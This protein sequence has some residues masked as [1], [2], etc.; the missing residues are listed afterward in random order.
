M[1][2][3]ISRIVIK[4]SQ[5]PYNW[6]IL[7]LPSQDMLSFSVL[8]VYIIGRKLLHSTKF[9]HREVFNLKIVKHLGL[10]TQNEDLTK[11]VLLHV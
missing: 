1:K 9:K 4:L 10:T 5:F 2:S 7:F 3:Q 6:I 11:I 8:G